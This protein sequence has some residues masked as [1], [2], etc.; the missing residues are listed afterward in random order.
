MSFGNVPTGRDVWLVCRRVVDCNL[1]VYIQD[2]V[3]LGLSPCTRKTE[4]EN[5][6]DFT[7][8]NV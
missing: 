1:S 3:K 7:M 4:E 2:V 5:F 6:K 8:I